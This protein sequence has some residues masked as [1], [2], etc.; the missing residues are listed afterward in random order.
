[1]DL[2]RGLKVHYNVVG[3]VLVG[4]NAQSE[5]VHA[6]GFFLRRDTLRSDKEIR[7]RSFQILVA[8]PH[9]TSQ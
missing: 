4:N 7:M 9:A 1:M 3:M 8:I 6:M 2:E 5:V